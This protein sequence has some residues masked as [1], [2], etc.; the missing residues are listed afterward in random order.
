[1]SSSRVWRTI[2][3][4][5]LTS[6]AIAAAWIGLS[7]RKRTASIF[8][9]TLMMERLSLS[10]TFLDCQRR[11]RH[12]RRCGVG[13]PYV[14]RT[15]KFLLLEVYFT[16]VGQEKNPQKGVDPVA[17]AAQL[18]YQLEQG[19]QIV[20]VEQSAEYVLDPADDHLD[21]LVVGQLEDIANIVYLRLPLE[22][23]PG[24]VAPLRAGGVDP[25][26]FSQRFDQLLESDLPL[27]E[28]LGVHPAHQRPLQVG[29]GYLAG[30]R[31]GARVV[32][33]RAAVLV[34]LHEV[35]EGEAAVIRGERQQRFRLHAQEHRGVKED[36]SALSQ[37]L[38]G[39]SRYRPQ[40]PVG[41]VDDVDVL[42]VDLPFLGHP[43][44]DL[45]AAL[46]GSGHFKRALG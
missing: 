33:D 37:V 16:G 24:R 13:S 21:V 26:G 46:A 34:E 10:G 19:H 12:R 41:D 6:L 11:F 38:L 5:I 2:C 4:S 28:L 32:D 44:E 7:V 20:V 29:K 17:A 36:L 18:P 15:I 31:L 27:P 25:L 35:V 23:D 1:M 14:Q 43:H 42:G 40:E 22:V 45:D 3:T 30:H 8:A 9:L 39:G